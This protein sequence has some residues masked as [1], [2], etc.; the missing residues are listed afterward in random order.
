MKL[1]IR[2]FASIREHLGV[3]QEIVD[4]HAPG[5][6]VEGIR[7]TLASRDARSALALQTHRPVRAAVNLELV[8]G[9]FVVREDSEIAFFPPVTGG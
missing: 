3:T 2:Y 8:D 9:A 1:T 4:I 7:E 6:T 5:I